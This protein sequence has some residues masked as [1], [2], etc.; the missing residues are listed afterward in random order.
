MRLSNSTNALLGSALF[1]LVLLS[2]DNML[3]LFYFDWFTT[4]HHTVAI[5]SNFLK[6]NSNSR[7][8]KLLDWHANLA[9]AIFCMTIF[10]IY[11][12]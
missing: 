5:Q 6:V 8:E 9:F 4:R 7:I 2:L 3:S 11:Y 12:F 1:I 10:A